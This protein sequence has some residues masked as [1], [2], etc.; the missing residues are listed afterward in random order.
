[1]YQPALTVKVLP[2]SS[3]IRFLIVR[4]HSS[5]R[6][7]VVV[8]MGRKE[9]NRYMISMSHVTTQYAIVVLVQKRLF[10]RLNQLH[11]CFRARVMVLVIHF[12][13]ALESPCFLLG[14]PTAQP[15]LNGSIRHRYAIAK[16][17]AIRSPG[18]FL[19]AL[20]SLPGN[21]GY[22]IFCTI[23]GPLGCTSFDYIVHLKKQEQYP[24][25]H[26]HRCPSS[27]QMVTV[28]VQGLISGSVLQHVGRA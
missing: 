2:V 3:T 11:A 14:T 26:H 5:W 10:E 22:H 1:M 6:Q 16:Q 19:I 18:D 27:H 9:T 20:F 24:K 28:M 25:P 17:L 7:P 23:V 21:L 15:L 12:K 13:W 8:G 4:W